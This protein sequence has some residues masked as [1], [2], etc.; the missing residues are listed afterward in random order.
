MSDGLTQRSLIVSMK[1]PVIFFFL[2][3]IVWPKK[4]HEANPPSLID[5]IDHLLF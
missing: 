2:L 4:N 5:S 3:K 1:N